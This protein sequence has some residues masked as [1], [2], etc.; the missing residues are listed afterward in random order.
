MQAVL[1]TTLTRG[2]TR[3]ARGAQFHGHPVTMGAPNDYRVV[4][5]SQALSSIH[6]IYF[7]KISGSNV[8]APNLL[9]APVAI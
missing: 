5:K 8:G 2:I 3:G 4:E 6:Y 9:L 1:S 7:Q